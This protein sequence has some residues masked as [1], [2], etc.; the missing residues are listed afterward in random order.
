MNVDRHRRARELFLAACDLPLGRRSTYLDGACAGDAELHREVAALLRFDLPATDSLEE[1]SPPER[2]GD[3]RLLRKLGEGGMGEVWEAEQERPVRRRVAFKLVKWGMDTR[4]VLAR[5]ESERQALALMSHPNIARVYEAGSTEEGRPF[6]A[7]EYVEGV[8]L[9]EYC[10]VRRLST[11]ERLTLFM[12]VCDGVQ[13]AHQKGI[14]HRDVKPSNVL[15]AAEGGRPVPKIIDF[16]VAKATSQR[17][18]ER[19]LFT[20]LGQWIGTP[21]YMSP[22]Q[23]ELGGLDIDTRSDV[24]SLGVV[25]YELLAGAQPFDA[26]ELRAAGFD[27]MRRRIREE[28]PP[29]PS[30]RVSSRGDA[31][32]PAAERRRTDAD[33]LARSLRGDL[34]W[35]VMKAMEKDRSRRY[36]SASDLAADAGRYLRHEPVAASPPSA[37]YRIH[38]FVRRHRAGVAAALLIL[39]AL[40]AGVAGTAMGIVKA[41]S[42]AETAHRVSEVLVGLFADLDPGGQMGQ[43]SSATAMLDRGVERITGELAGQ[44]LVQARLLETVGRAYRNLGRFDEARPPLEQALTLREANLGTVHALVADSCVELGWLEYWTA[45]YQQA[46]SLFERAVTIYQQALGPDHRA[47]ASSLGFT[48]SVRWRTG[49]YRG[50]RAAFER[51]L[52][53]LRARGMEDDP[54][55]VNTVLPYA[56]M[57]MDV[58]E[59][60]SARPLLERGLAVSEARFGPDHPTVGWL[61]AS[62]G[63]LFQETLRYDRARPQLERALRIHEGLLGPDHPNLIL[64]L[65]HLGMLDRQERKLES[66]GAYLERALAIAER[67]LGPDHPDLVYVLGAYGL[68]L[69][70]RGD[71]EG[72][73]ATLERAR[74]VAEACHGPHHLDVARAVETSGFQAYLSGDYRGALRQYRR[75]HEIRER[76]FG[77]GHA[78]AGWNLYDQA[79]LLA[80]AGDP[81]TALATLRRALES[82]WASARIFEDDDFDSLRGDPGFE[83]ILAEVRERL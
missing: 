56:A 37:S 13:H 10:D 81:A 30:T 65:T 60:A 79:C 76:V 6:F 33:G 57:L 31:S 1:R 11:R 34:D 70:H 22:E 64:P 75:A 49:D 42:E 18:T 36:G 48:G 83:A 25:L 32:R 73:R 26:R 9:T 43:I 40:C 12:Q 63:R 62:L 78:A 44:P 69:H 55:I 45:D 47:V 8:P 29:K 7:M 72:A 19:T 46:R 23:A 21:E 53:I 77:P 27:E 20:E 52:A 71:P 68:L 15:V 16:G 51:S 4:E 66:A 14:I 24:Y 67:T 74:Q 82:G 61:T 80:L 50:A 5:F 58:A 17:L 28:E 54:V 3:F 39:A 38:K 2:I 41:R 59:H 35:I